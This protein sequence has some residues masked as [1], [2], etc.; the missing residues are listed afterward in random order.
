MLFI[1]KYTYFYDNLMFIANNNVPNGLGVATKSPAMSDLTLPHNLS[2]LAMYLPTMAWQH[3]GNNCL[4]L[5]K[6]IKGCHEVAELV[7]A[8]N[9]VAMWM[10]HC[11]SVTTKLLAL[12]I[13]G[14]YVAM[15]M[16]QYHS[17]AKK[18]LG[19]VIAGS[20]VTMS[21]HHC[22]SVAMKLLNFKIAS[23]AVEAAQS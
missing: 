19:L 9:Y 21:M 17:V 8:G 23:E 12:V 13:A 22:H 16:H 5:P 10:Y 14:N 20:Y 2:L 11:H 18:L 15:W 4:T 1:K 3:F 6:A 7:I